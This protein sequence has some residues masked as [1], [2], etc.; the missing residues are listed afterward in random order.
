LNK[1]AKLENFVSEIQHRQW[2]WQK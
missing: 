2:K 1:Y